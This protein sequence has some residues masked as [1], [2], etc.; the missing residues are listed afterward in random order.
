[1]APCSKSSNAP[2]SKQTVFPGNKDQATA[3]SERGSPSG[4]T[5]RQWADHVGCATSRSAVLTNRIIKTTNTHILA[6]F[7]SPLNTLSSSSQH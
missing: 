6:Y 1:M 3:E 5:G 7:Q 2:T 4:E